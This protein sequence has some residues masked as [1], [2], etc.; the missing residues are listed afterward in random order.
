MTTIEVLRSVAAL[1]FLSAASPALAGPIGP[2]LEFDFDEG[3]GTTALNSGSLGAGSNGVLSGATYSTDSAFESGFSLQFDGDTDYV[4]VVDTFDYGDAIT[5]EMWIKPTALDGQRALY[6]D[7]GNPGVFMAI[8]GGQLQLT[9]STAGDP[10][11]GVS[12]FDGEI[13]ADLWQ[14]VAVAYDGATIRGWINGIEVGDGVATSGAIIDNGGNPTHIGADSA[15]PSLLEFSGRMDDF[16]LFHASVP[17]EKPRLLCGELTGDCEISTV[18]A[19]VALRMAVALV[20][21]EDAA[22]FDASGGVS[23]SDALAILR[24]AVDILTQSN[25]CNDL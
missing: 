21:A 17:P 2:A 1:S 4:E 11:P 24:V 5:I 15:T 7:Y 16:R 14:H 10:G 23:A 6:D 20:D 18:D 22:D 3:T 8:S 12:I 19:L 13:C 9:L 25:A